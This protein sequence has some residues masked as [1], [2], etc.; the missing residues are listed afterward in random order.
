MDNFSSNLRTFAFLEL[1]TE[2]KTQTRNISS[3]GC[4]NICVPG[5]VQLG[6]R[7]RPECQSSKLHAASSPRDRA[8]LPPK[9]S[10]GENYVGVI[11]GC[12]PAAVFIF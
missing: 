11:I 10:A 5:W 4:K 7:V 8:S 1:V 6:A 12:L 2:P 3:V 9:A